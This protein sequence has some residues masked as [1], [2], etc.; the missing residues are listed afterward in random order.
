MYTQIR[1]SKRLPFTFTAWPFA[2]HTIHVIN[3]VIASVW[4][5][6][7]FVRSAA[8]IIC[9]LYMHSGRSNTLFW[10]FRL[11]SWRLAYGSTV[12]YN[13]MNW[14]HSIFNA[15]SN[16]HIPSYRRRRR[17]K[18]TNNI[19]CW[20]LKMMDVSKILKSDECQYEILQIMLLRQIKAWRLKMWFNN[21]FFSNGKA[22]QEAT[23][24]KKN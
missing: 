7:L 6:S 22:V 21:H 13:V 10:L 8:F 24:A 9:T 15:H 2:I 18:I 20:M 19:T 12:C 5:Y 17:K 16:I 11:S 14:F 3:S 4:V 23:E 1:S